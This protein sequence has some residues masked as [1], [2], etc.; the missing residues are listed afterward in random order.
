MKFIELTNSKRLAAVDDADIERIILLD[1]KWCVRFDNGKAEAIMSTRR[2]GRKR[3]A[4]L[5]H[6][7]VMNCHHTTYPYVD[8][9]DGNIFD[10]RKCNLRFA[11]FSQNG[12]NR[13]KQ[14]NNTSGEK[15]ISWHKA[16]KRWSIKLVIEGKPRHIG[17]YSTIESAKTARD[18]AVKRFCGDFS[19]LN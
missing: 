14:C 1:T 16:T 9:I 8:H 18:E 5:L 19:R 15:N 10:D 12:M 4:I 6:R 2:F 11:T 7:F 3:H 17:Y 13:S